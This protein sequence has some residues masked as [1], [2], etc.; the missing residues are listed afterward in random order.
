MVPGSSVANFLKMS[1]NS[2]NQN[3]I[4][5]SLMIKSRTKIH[6]FSCDWNQRPD[7]NNRYRKL[8]I[9]D[10]LLQ[11]SA[12]SYRRG[13]PEISKHTFMSVYLPRYGNLI[14]RFAKTYSLDSFICHRNLETLWPILISNSILIIRRS[15]ARTTLPA[16]GLLCCTSP[17]LRAPSSCVGLGPPLK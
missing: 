8:Q 11:R 1:L 9:S 14:F 10:A 6:H 5:A 13:Y 12:A 4:M 3:S 17:I 15:Y 2:T 16:P 7:W